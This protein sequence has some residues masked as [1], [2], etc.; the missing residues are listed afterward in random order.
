MKKRLVE[1]GRIGLLVFNGESDLSKT[2]DSILSQTY[3][4]FALVMSDDAWSDIV[5]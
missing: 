1:S 3:G 2:L 4:D 5:Q